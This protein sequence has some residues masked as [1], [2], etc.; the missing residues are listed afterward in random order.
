MFD[1]P[2]VA[3]TATSE[4]AAAK[5]AARENAGDLVVEY[6][7]TGGNVVTTSAPF[8]QGGAV[9]TDLDGDSMLAT[10]GGE[11]VSPGVEVTAGL[12]AWVTAATGVALGEPVEDTTLPR[13]ARYMHCSLDAMADALES[14]LLRFEDALLA[15]HELPEPTPVGVTSQQEALVVGRILT[16][17]EA[18]TGRINAR[19]VLLEGSRATSNGHRV[20][21]DLSRLPEYTFFPGQV[22]AC[23]G[24]ATS[25]TSFAVTRVHTEAPLPTPHSAVD[26]LQ[27]DAQVAAGAAAGAVTGVGSDGRGGGPLRVW[28]ACGPFT[29]NSDLEYSPLRDFLAEVRGAETVPDA[30]VLMGP[31]VS[32]EHPSISAGAVTVRNPQ[33]GEFSLT[34]RELWEL[35]ICPLLAQNLD[36][37]ATKGIRV[38]LVPSAD[39][40]LCHSV[41]PT[42]AYTTSAGET[43]GKLPGG[44]ELGAYDLS[45]LPESLRSRTTC[46]GSPGVFTIGDGGERV[47]FGAMSADVLFHLNVADASRMAAS[48][49][50]R[51]ARWATLAG[52]LTG[53][54]SWYPL[55][56]PA[57]G[58]PVDLAW[59]QHLDMP[60]TPDVMLLPSKLPP[61]VAA[62]TEGAL[63]VGM[64]H[65]SKFNVAGTY[66]VLEVYPRSAEHAEGSKQGNTAEG[67]PMHV[68]P[69]RVSERSVVRVMRV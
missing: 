66:G 58:C 8:L 29:L 59:A 50:G 14:R 46:V 34:F 24:I 3:T 39:D 49:S 25:D 57:E 63:C 20:R 27:R 17:S 30:I 55:Y 67:A 56:P 19:S 15:A 13:S 41:V 11:S 68:G 62:Q 40:M 65:L 21:L 18:G 38:V 51:S 53:Q 6:R 69:H 16:E 10:Q 22:V 32:A 4:E 12:P 37:A 26:V 44:V 35:K 7:P 42:P 54:R 45:P 64:G 1:K 43:Q 28:S 48:P 33:G 61:F 52:Q 23:E 2:A 31:F 5:F 36:T 60:F 9:A 47:V